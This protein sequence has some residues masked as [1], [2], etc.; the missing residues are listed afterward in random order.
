MYTAIVVR[1]LVTTDSGEY[2]NNAALM[3]KVSP[4]VDEY[5]DKYS[6]HYAGNPYITGEVP[7][8]IRKD[9]MKLMISGILIMILLLYMNIRNLKAV[10][11]ILAVIIL[12][13][14]SMNG[15]MGWLFHLTENEIFNF[16][17]TCII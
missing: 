1:S 5:L 3:N 17:I 16:T 11:M 10:S 4:I 15:F 13:V 14:I 9:A 12:S 7:K 8:L 2:R 6:V